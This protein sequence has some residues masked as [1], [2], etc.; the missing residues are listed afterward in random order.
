MALGYTDNEV[1]E[2]LKC[3]CYTILAL[4]LNWQLLIFDFFLI[5][6]LVVLCIVWLPKFSFSEIF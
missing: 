5:V 4:L 6:L 2:F 1:I 3:E